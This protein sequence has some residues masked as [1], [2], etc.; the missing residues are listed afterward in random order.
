MI[1]FSLDLETASV[2]P[3]AAITQIGLAVAIDNEIREDLGLNLKINTDDYDGVYKGEFDV[4]IS[5]MV[6]W[7]RQDPAAFNEAFGHPNPHNIPDVNDDRLPLPTALSV[8]SDEVDKIRTN[9]GRAA[10]LWAKPK[11]FDIA[12]LRHAYKQMGMKSLFPCHFREERCL[13]TILDLVPNDA[14]I[15][16]RPFTDGA[17][18]DAYAD[19]LH[20][21]RQLRACLIKL[22][23]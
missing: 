2:A 5:C 23:R 15:H 12:I 11:L 17:R 20:Q 8:L 22:G 14:S 9:N 18:H 13:K 1:D 19:A 3:N 21:A 10:R 4:E 16:G 6:W 7:S